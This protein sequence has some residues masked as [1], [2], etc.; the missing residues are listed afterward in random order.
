MKKIYSILTLAALLSA[1]ETFAQTKSVSGTTV[2]FEGPWT[3]EAINYEISEADGNPV[4]TVIVKDVEGLEDATITP[5]NPNTIIVAKQGQVA[6]EENVVLTVG[7]GVTWEHMRKLHIYDGFGFYSTYKFDANEAYYERACRNEYNTL[8]LPFCFYVEELNT[9]GDD[10]MHLEVLTDVS[11]DVL[12]FKRVVDLNSKAGTRPGHHVPA[13]TP[14][15]CHLHGFIPA[16]SVATD[17]ER[18]NKN[19]IV[20]HPAGAVSVNCEEEPAFEDIAYTLEGQFVPTV[21]DAKTN[22]EKYYIADNF[23]WKWTDFKSGEEYA[24]VEVP[25]FRCILNNFNTDIENVEEAAAKKLSI[26]TLEGETAIETVKTTIETPAYNLMGVRVAPNA[27][28]MVIKNG[29]KYFNK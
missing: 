18:A 12:I 21:I 11:K 4:G 1:G 7:N 23:F 25:A 13:G 5:A 27:K 17:E 2:T 28:G 8:C 9:D 19:R 22:T 6:N 24:T 14:L 20:I 3:I 10:N 29:K 16:D 15:I 26:I